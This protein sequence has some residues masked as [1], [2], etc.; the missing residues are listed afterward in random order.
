M[1]LVQMSPKKTAASGGKDAAGAGAKPKK[2]K[3]S[4]SRSAVVVDGMPIGEMSREQVED[5]VYRTRSELDRERV[6]RNRAE[7]E[8]TKVTSFWALSRAESN[9]VNESLIDRDRELEDVAKRHA[10]QVGRRKGRKK[11]FDV[12]QTKDKACHQTF[13][14]ALHF[15]NTP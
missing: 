4:S 15:K 8:L 3:S 10:Q 2:K 9:S 12:N 7:L 5:L 14:S 13:F 1:N 6:A 11:I